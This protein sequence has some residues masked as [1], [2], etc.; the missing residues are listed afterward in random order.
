MTV[1]GMI[2]SKIFPRESIQRLSADHPTAYGCLSRVFRALE[3]LRID[4]E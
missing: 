4:L 2:S 1:G 3:H